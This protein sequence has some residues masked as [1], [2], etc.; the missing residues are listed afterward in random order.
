MKKQGRESLSFFL[1]ESENF[2]EGTSKCQV[3]RKMEGEKFM[4]QAR[5]Y[6]RWGTACTQYVQDQP[7]R[8][9]AWAEKGEE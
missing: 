7:L 3:L 5:E 4:G 6:S 1:G 9:H 2:T 8:T